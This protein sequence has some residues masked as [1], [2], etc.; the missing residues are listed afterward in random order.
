MALQ[1]GGSRW[2]GIWAGWGFLVLATRYVQS[3]NGLLLSRTGY[4]CE[5]LSWIPLFFISQSWILFSVGSILLAS[6][7]FAGVQ[8]DDEEETDFA[9]VGH[10]LGEGWNLWMRFW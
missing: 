7:G 2:R 9:H 4:P 5:I 8:A 3:E 1:Q 6:V 10:E